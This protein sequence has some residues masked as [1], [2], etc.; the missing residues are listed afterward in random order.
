MVTRPI[1]RATERLWIPARDG[2]SVQTRKRDDSEA[3]RIAEEHRRR[4]VAR[5]DRSKKAAGE[6]GAAAGVDHE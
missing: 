6:I 5:R 4:P 1:S 3:R 2:T